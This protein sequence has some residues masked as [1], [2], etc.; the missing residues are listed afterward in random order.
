MNTPCVNDMTLSLT[1]LHIMFQVIFRLGY[2]NP[3]DFYFSP[4]F[5]FRN[6]EFHRLYCCN[7]YSECSIPLFIVQL[8][9]FYKASTKIEDTHYYDTPGSF[10]FLS[11]YVH[12]GAVISGFIEPE[13][14]LFS[15]NILTF[16]FL[17][18]KLFSNSSIGINKIYSHTIPLT[19]L[20][21]AYLAFEFIFSPDSRNVAKLFIFFWSHLYF[22]IRFMPSTST[23]FLQAPLWLDQFL[24]KIFMTMD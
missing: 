23:R 16:I 13:P 21:F 1:I 3:L 19:F 10:L 5:I 8:Y 18:C 17:Y 14:G 12:I 6:Y 11:F 22:V 2:L 24:L 20:P 15:R 4:H 9:I 7:F